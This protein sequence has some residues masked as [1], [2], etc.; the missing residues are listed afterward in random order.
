LWRLAAARTTDGGRTEDGW[1]TDGERTRPCPP[2]TD[3]EAVAL[4][5]DPGHAHCTHRLPGLLHPVD[6][7]FGPEETAVDLVRRLDAG[8]DGADNRVTLAALPGYIVLIGADGPFCTK[9]RLTNVN[10]AA[11]D[12][13]P[14]LTQ[15]QPHLNV[16]LTSWLL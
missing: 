2:S 14:L 6:R 9:R 11:A 13:A 3:E 4:Y 12:L 7:L 10:P 16:T 8:Y 1:R 5:L 15:C